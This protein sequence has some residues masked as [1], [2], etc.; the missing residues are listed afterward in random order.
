MKII[1]GVNLLHVGDNK[2][3]LQVVLSL[4]GEPFVVDNFGSNVNQKECA[5]AFQNI[6]KMIGKPL[7]I[8][9]YEGGLIFVTPEGE[10]FRFWLAGVL[11][12]R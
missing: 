4:D 2:I 5:L 12:D 7:S 9:H 11:S 6:R 10:H 3:N 8:C 1:T